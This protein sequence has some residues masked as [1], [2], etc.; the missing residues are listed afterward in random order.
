M[1]VQNLSAGITTSGAELVLVVDLVAAVTND[2]G[3]R[4]I[5]FLHAVDS[6]ARRVVLG[7]DLSVAGVGSIVV[8][9]GDLGDVLAVRLA[10]VLDSLDW[11]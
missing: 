10:V 5:G 7:A 2:A 8:E 4:H 3:G 6:D 1:P 11:C 9:G